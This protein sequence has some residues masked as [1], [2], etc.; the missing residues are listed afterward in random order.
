MTEPIAIGVQPRECD[1]LISLRLRCGVAR[2][3]SRCRH[4]FLE[5]AF[6]WLDDQS[7]ATWLDDGPGAR[8]FEASVRSVCDN[9]DRFSPALLLSQLRPL[10]G[11]PAADRDALREALEKAFNDGFGPRVVERRLRERLQ[12]LLEQIADRAGGKE[13]SGRLQAIKDSAGRLYEEMK[14]LPGGF[15][16]P[17]PGGAGGCRC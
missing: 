16:L 4:S 17:P 6:L 14:R 5:N 11:L 9:L 15:W 8:D 10:A 1:A 12:E 2:E 7:L 3:A 13:R